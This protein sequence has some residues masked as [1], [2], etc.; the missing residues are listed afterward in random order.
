[1]RVRISLG[2]PFREAIDAA[3][4]GILVTTSTG[5]MVPF[6]YKS[7]PKE[8][9]IAYESHNQGLVG[10]LSWINDLANRDRLLIGKPLSHGPP[11]RNFGT[12]RVI[13]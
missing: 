7:K 5:R 2:P 6:S 11:D 13:C 10:C 4:L 1:M 8:P 3:F 9:R 12:R